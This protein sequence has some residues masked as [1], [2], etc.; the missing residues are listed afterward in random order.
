M[1]KIKKDAKGR[2]ELLSLTANTFTE[3]E[4][5]D[6]TKKINKVIEGNNGTIIENKE[7]GKKRLAYTIKKFNFGYYNL[8]V[9][10]IDRKEIE[11]INRLLN[12]MREILRF[13]IVKY[14]IPYTIKVGLPEVKIVKN[15]VI[16]GK[17]ST[18][19]ATATEEIKEETKAT[20]PKAEKVTKESIKVAKE[21]AEER[22]VLETATEEAHAETEK[23]KDENLD[24]KLDNILEAKDLF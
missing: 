24:K 14:I 21:K 17:P 22:I 3:D 20:K 9:F 10:D 23:K 16:E 4:A 11:T 2:F 12:Q 13:T 7:W 15:P 5:R 8:V 1:S 18:S 6:I 19:K